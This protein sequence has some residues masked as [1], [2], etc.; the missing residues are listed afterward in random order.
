[1]GYKI[2]ITDRSFTFFVEIVRLC[3]LEQKNRVSR[4]LANQLLH[5]VTSI[6][7]NIEEASLLA[8]ESKELVGIFTSIVK[9][10]QEGVNNGK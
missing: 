7:V 1:M 5:S 3:L 9:T 2:K 4:T 8:K 6:G 10:A